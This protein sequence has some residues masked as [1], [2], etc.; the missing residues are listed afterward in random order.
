[1]GFAVEVMSM[2]ANILIG[3]LLIVLSRGEIK[4]RLRDDNA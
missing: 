4:A 1:M 2:A 3:S